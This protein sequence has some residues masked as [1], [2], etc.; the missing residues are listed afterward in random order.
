MDSIYTS[1][2]VQV[3][4]RKFSAPLPTRLVTDY[5]SPKPNLNL[6]YSAYKYR[7]QRSQSP[8]EFGDQEPESRLLNSEFM[9]SYDNPDSCQENRG[10]LKSFKTFG[11]GE[12][13]PKLDQENTR[14]LTMENGNEYLEL[15]PGSMDLDRILESELERLQHGNKNVVL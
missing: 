11:I 12:F 10:L 13:G 8:L 3:P 14:N 2:Q 9:Q 15:N 4:E 6:K 1:G 7:S 5:G